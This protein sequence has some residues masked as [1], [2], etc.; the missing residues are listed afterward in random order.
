MDYI[1][2]GKVFRDKDETVVGVVVPWGWQDIPFIKLSGKKPVRNDYGN[3]NRPI[4]PREHW[5]PMHRQVCAIFSSQTCRKKGK[6]TVDK[7]APKPVQLPEIV[8]T[9]YGSIRKE[10][11]M[12]NKMIADYFTRHPS[13]NWDKSA[14]EVIKAGKNLPIRPYYLSEIEKQWLEN[15]KNCGVKVLTEGWLNITRWDKQ[16]GQK[17]R[18]VPRRVMGINSA[19]RMQDHILDV[20]RLDKEDGLGELSKINSIQEIIYQAKDLLID[21]Q[22]AGPREKEKIQKQLALVILHLEKCRNEFKVNAKK[23]AKKALPLKDLLGRINPGAMAARTIAALNQLTKRLGQLQIIMPFI[24]MRKELLVLEK[25]RLDASVSKAVGKLR[26]VSRHPVFNGQGIAQHELRILA[27]EINKSM[28]FLNTA[29]ISPYWEQA[30]QAKLFL[31]NAKKF[32]HSKRFAEAGKTLNI[33]LSILET[34][35]NEFG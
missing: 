32:I 14:F 29:W 13:K 6:E 34:D 4:I 27:I 20:Y 9:K 24:A 23:Q 22:N 12:L 35:L 19:L 15:L 7:P 30:N 26:A 31:S 21:W 3:P 25:R 28:S 5:V 8:I 10:A 16:V 18:L 17:P 11:N 33:A 2:G 1:K